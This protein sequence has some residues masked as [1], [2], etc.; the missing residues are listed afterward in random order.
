MVFKYFNL[1][2]KGYCCENGCVGVCNYVVILLVDDILNVVCEVV[3][4]NVK[5]IMVLFYVY[6]CLQFGE[7]FELYFCIM[8]GIGVNLNV[9]VVVVIGI[10]SGWIKCIVDGICVIGKFVLEFFIEQKGDFEIICVVSWV[11]KEY[12]Y[13]V[14]EL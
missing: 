13:W 9:V 12:V 6:G 3:V 10:E 11:V 8:I 7:D 14:I 5:G 1:I 2:V 4:N